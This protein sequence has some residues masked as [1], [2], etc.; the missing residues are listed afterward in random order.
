[1]GI[2]RAR[3]PASPICGRCSPTSGV[4][5]SRERI[6]NPSEN[7]GRRSRIRPTQRR[8]ADATESFARWVRNDGPDTH[9]VDGRETRASATD[10]RPSA[11]AAARA[12]RPCCASQAA[13]ENWSG[14]VVAAARA[15]REVGLTLPQAVETSA[16]SGLS[17]ACSASRYE[18]TR[19]PRAHTNPCSR[20]DANSS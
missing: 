16:I 17:A 12:S 10:G 18:G 3:G 14:F 2:A 1:M 4:T 7:V 20:C 6:V 9:G 8:D 11:K 5:R 19:D 13:R 15:R